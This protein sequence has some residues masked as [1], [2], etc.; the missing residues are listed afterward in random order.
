MN[1][2][3][4]SHMYGICSTNFKICDPDTIPDT[5]ESFPDI[6]NAKMEKSDV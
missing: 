3:E 5:S 4:W 1:E 6:G 2:W